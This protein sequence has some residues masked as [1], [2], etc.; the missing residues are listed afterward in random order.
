M[1]ATEI[2][3]ITCPQSP[4]SRSKGPTMT[5]TK[6]ATAAVLGATEK[7]AVTG[8]GAPRKRPAST[9]RGRYR[10]D[11]EGQ[12]H[13]DEDDAEQEPDRA[14]AAALERLLQRLEAGG[15]GEPIDHGGAEQQHARGE[16]PQDEI[17]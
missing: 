2:A 5:R 13:H 9:C 10:R 4:T 12:T 11:L 16:R 8:V 17:L 7:N 15:A 14:R 1:E 6:S 3:Q